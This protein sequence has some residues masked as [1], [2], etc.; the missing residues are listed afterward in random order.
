MLEEE[1][2]RV[3]VPFKDWSRFSTP[4][5]DRSYPQFAEFLRSATR[6]EYVYPAL[7]EIRERMKCAIEEA[8]V[9]VDCKVVKKGRPHQLVCTKNKA[10]YR[11]ALKVRNEDEERLKQVLELQARISTCDR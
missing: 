1:L 5:I 3:I 8:G 11:H 2:A 7:K 4:E 10:S 6:K 9:D